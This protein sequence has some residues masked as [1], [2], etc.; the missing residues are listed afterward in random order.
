MRKDKTKNG[1]IKIDVEK[2]LE[3]NPHIDRTM[4]INAQ[5]QQNELRMFGVK[6]RTFNLLLPFMRRTPVGN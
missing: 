6:R 5:K 1:K 4:L 3:S 2:I